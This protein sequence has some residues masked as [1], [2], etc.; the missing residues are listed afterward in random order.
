MPVVVGGEGVAEEDEGWAL[1]VGEAG[2]LGA[3]GGHFRVV[4]EVEVFGLVVGPVN[5]LRVEGVE[6]GAVPGGS[7]GGGRVGCGCSGGEEAVGPVFGGFA[8]IDLAD[9]VSDDVGRPGGGADGG[10]VGV[11]SGDAVDEDVGVGEIEAGI[12]AEGHHAGGGVDEGGA[13]EHAEDGVVFVGAQGVLAG[14]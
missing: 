6:V 8:G 7:V 1:G 9:D 14:G 5:E 3:E 11:Y 2:E 13:R 4:A 12:E 10:D